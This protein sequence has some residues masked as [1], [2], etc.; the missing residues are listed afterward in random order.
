MM[1]RH[2][3]GDTEATFKTAQ[4]GGDDVDCRHLG[5]QELKDDGSFDAVLMSLG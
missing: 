4:A 3:H 5:V 1:W 2:G